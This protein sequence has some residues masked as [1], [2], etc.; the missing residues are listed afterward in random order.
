VKAKLPLSGGLNIRMVPK[1]ELFRVKMTGT[2]TLM[3][4]AA[5]QQCFIDGEADLHRSQ[6]SGALKNCHLEIN[7]CPVANQLK[8][9]TRCSS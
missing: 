8:F 4:A 5:D 7:H 6:S 3:R 9:M 1:Y 2:A